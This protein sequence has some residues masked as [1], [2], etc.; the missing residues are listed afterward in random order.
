MEE[1]FQWFLT[2]TDLV[3]Q[4]HLW[5]VIVMGNSYGQDC[6]PA[7]VVTA[8]RLLSPGSAP[9]RPSQPQLHRAWWQGHSHFQQTTH[10]RNG[11]FSQLWVWSPLFSSALQRMEANQAWAIM[12]RVM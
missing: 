9:T 5:W 3:L 11:Q 12:D 8:A 10:F 4:P 2:H 7:P 6:L 1:T